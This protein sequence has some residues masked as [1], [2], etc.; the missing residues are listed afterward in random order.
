MIKVDR[1]SGVYLMHLWGVE[2]W[3][4]IEADY[5]VWEGCGV[6]ALIDFDDVIELHMAMRKDDRRHCR[7]FV[8]NILNMC[9][10]PVR[11][12]IQEKNRH[13]CNLALR[14]GFD[15]VDHYWSEMYDGSFK[16]VIEM[17]NDLWD[18]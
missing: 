6:C 3:P 7:V 2:D 15:Y 14:M 10:K 4:D 9:E 12:L 5:Y 8:K 11:A 16:Q 18:S 1:D 17:R 13:V